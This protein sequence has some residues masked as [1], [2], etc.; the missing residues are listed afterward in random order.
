M[1]F[2]HYFAI[3]FLFILVCCGK[4]TE[5]T[6]TPEIPPEEKDKLMEFALKVAEI[7]ENGKRDS[8][9]NFYP[10]LTRT[11]SISLKY[12]PDSITIFQTEP[13][14]YDIRLSPEVRI[15]VS[16]NDK[17]ELYI[18]ESY[19]LIAFRDYLLKPAIAGG[20]YDFTLP[21]VV[22]AERMKDKDYFDYFN[23][24]TEQKI[25]SILLTDVDID[26]ELNTNFMEVVKQGGLPQLYITIKNN[27]D[28]E[29]NPADFKF[30]LEGTFSAFL[31][32]GFSDNTWLVE[33]EG[34]KLAPGDSIVKFYDYGPNSMYYFRGIQ[35]NLT[36]S[37]LIERFVKYS[38][39][40]Y[41]DY[42]QAKLNN[43]FPVNKK[44]GVEENEVEIRRNVSYKE[45]VKKPVV[46][47]RRQHRSK[48]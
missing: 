16:E 32:Q 13:D 10:D 22:L 34:V 14:V 30:T 21:D 3:A 12:S 1:K 20:M 43:E 8:L 2:L 47:N 45:D 6:V 38:A 42:L 27:T 4:K 35:Y 24:V 39:T 44:P 17:G 18:K 29:M 23:M 7:A 31:E 37:E 26:E 41:K 33:E 11:D 15:R 25:D 28:K 40:E 36:R 19:G 5:Q 48:R 9:R 46:N